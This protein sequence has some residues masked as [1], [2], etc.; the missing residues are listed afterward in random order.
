MRKIIVPKSIA[1][2]VIHYVNHHHAPFTENELGEE[3]QL[4]P[5]PLQLAIYF[6]TTEGLARKKVHDNVLLFVPEHN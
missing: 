3:L 5:H 1:L 2:P 6:L 4:E